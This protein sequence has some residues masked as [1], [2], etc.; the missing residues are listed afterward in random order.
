MD[1]E[2]GFLGGRLGRIGGTRGWFLLSLHPTPGPSRDPRRPDARW[3]LALLG[4]GSPKEREVELAI[5]G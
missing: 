4:K 1:G 2:E 3:Q 5:W